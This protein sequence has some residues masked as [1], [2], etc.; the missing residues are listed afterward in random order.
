MKGKLTVVSAAAAALAIGLI[1]AACGSASGSP[2]SSAAYGQQAQP[3]TANGTAGAAKVHVANS[4]LGRILVNSNGR[5]L[6][7]FEKDKNHRSACSGVCATYW[8]PLLTQGKPVAGAGAKQSLLGTT[9]RANG[10]KQ[11]TYAGHPLYRFSGDTQR[12]QT[13]GAGL[14]DFGGGWDPLS[15]A[16]RKIETGG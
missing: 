2:Y 5:T 12:G 14:Q 3:S 8:P 13:N 9:R 1:A 6:Y 10:S 7:L 16:G 15:P 11:V 4:R